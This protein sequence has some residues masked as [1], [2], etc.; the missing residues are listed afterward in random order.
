V[1]LATETVSQ[2]QKESV[3]LTPCRM[4]VICHRRKRTKALRVIWHKC[5]V[6]RGTIMPNLQF[7][8][9]NHITGMGTP[10]YMTHPYPL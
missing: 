6:P 4:A 2:Q 1:N 5:H 7:T 3:A 9:P 10:C 8:F